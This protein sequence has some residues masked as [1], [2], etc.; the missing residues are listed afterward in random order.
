MGDGDRVGGADG[1]V[2][3]E[4]SRVGAELAVHVTQ[5]ERRP[6]LLSLKHRRLS[7]LRQNKLSWTVRQRTQSAW[8]YT[9]R[10]Q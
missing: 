7:T 1:V 8:P 5:S 9:G 6:L 10:W 2:E 4:S 3:T